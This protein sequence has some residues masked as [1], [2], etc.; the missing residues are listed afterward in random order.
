MIRQLCLSKVCG[1]NRSISARDPVKQTQRQKYQLTTEY[2]GVWSSP[3]FPVLR[4]TLLIAQRWRSTYTLH[5][6]ST[7]LPFP[8]FLSLLFGNQSNTQIFNRL[9]PIIVSFVRV[10]PPL[11]TLSTSSGMHHPGPRSPYIMTHSFLPAHPPPPT[12][13]QLPST[14]PCFFSPILHIPR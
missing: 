11:P 3:P 4:G 2:L 6:A 1:Q 7:T 14:L 13:F 12:P 9:S 10:F 5:V 8:S